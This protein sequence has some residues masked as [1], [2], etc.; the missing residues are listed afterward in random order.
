MTDVP[1]PDDVE[2]RDCVAVIATRLEKQIQQISV[3]IR[4]AIENQVPELGRDARM[5]EML[6]AG[7]QANLQMIVDALLRD[8]PVDELSAPAAALDYAR[9]AAQHGLPSTAL[10]RGYRLGQRHVTELVFA[11]LRALNIDASVRVAVIEVI[12]TVVFEYI[13]RVSALVV[14]ELEDERRHWLQN[15]NS[16]RAMRVRDVLTDGTDVDVQTTSATIGYPLGRQH[17]A[18][19]AWYPDTAAAGDEPSRIQRFIAGLAAALD[20]S[21]DPLFAAADR[22]SAWIWLPFGSAPSRIVADIRAFARPRPESPNLALGAVGTGVEGFR[23]SHRQAQRVRAAVLAR[24]RESPT[25]PTLPG[26]KIAAATDPDMVATALLGTGVD[27]IRGW[28]ADVLGELA[29]DT[30]DDAELR[31]TLRVFLHSGSVHETAAGELALTFAALKSRVE[32]AVAR[33][34]RPIDDRRDVEMAL[35]TCHWYGSAVLRPA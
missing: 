13:D 2:V 14:S 4:T 33:R 35:F 9:R 11:E 18:L 15:Q 29:S 17:L 32:Q 26:P 3:T 22:N 24:G 34:G 21:S 19:I 28:V 5:S 10:V 23:R 16:I 30:A 1:G 20:T 31:E 25:A 12:T 27:E 6:A 8:T 7:V